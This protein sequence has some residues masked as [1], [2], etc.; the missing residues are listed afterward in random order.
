MQELFELPLAALLLQAR[1]MGRSRRNDP[2]VPQ[3]AIP[4]LVAH[5][6]EKRG[7]RILLHLLGSGKP[8]GEAALAVTLLKFG[9]NGPT[10]RSDSINC[11]HTL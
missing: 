7:E 2:H 8:F 3:A 6:I 1:D 9:P 11:N 10:K 5:G 4:R